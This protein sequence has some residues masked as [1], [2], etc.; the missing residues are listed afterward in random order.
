MQK[1]GFLN[2]GS[3]SSKKLQSLVKL[4]RKVVNISCY[5]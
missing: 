2:T 1:P 4:E 5:P 3:A